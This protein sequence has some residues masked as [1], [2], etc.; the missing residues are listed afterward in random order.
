MVGAGVSSATSKERRVA[1]APEAAIA[2]RQAELDQPARA[3]AV[4]RGRERTL[5]ARGDGGALAREAQLAQTVHTKARSQDEI[6]GA[7]RVS[8]VGATAWL[9]GVGGERVD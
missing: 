5:N 6:S 2:Q 9:R 7:P 1:R 4:E 3:A 8:R